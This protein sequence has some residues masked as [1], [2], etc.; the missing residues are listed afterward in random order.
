MAETDSSRV[1]A[2]AGVSSGATGQ[3][4]RTH[5]VLLTRR[6]TLLAALGRAEAFLADYDAV[7][8][9]TKVQVRLDH[10]ENVWKS[11]EEVQTELECAEESEEGMELHEEARASFEERL[12]I[13]KAELT[14]KLPVIPIDSQI[15]QTVH[16]TSA[17]SGLKLPTISLPE[18]DGDYMQ[19]LGFHDTFLALI[20]SNTDVPAIQ[21]FHYLKA[22]L[23]G[24]AAQLI[25]SIAISAANYNLAWDALVGRYANDYLL[26]KRHLQALFD[27]HPMK[28]ETAVTL[29][30]LVDEF[31]RHVKTL[32]QMGE[33]TAQWSS[34][35][36][37]LLC[38]RLHDD[39][40]KAWE[41]HASTVDDPNYSCLIDFLQRRMRVLESISVN[42]HASPCYGNSA[43]SNLKRSTQFR[44]SSNAATTNSGS[45]C[46]ACG[47]EH[48]ITRCQKFNGFSVAQRRQLVFKK[49]L[50]NN[51]LKGDHMAKDC[52]SNFNCRH[53]NMRHHSFLHSASYEGSQRSAPETHFSSTPVVV[54]NAPPLVG[55]PSVQSTVA[56]TENILD[57]EVSAPVQQPRENVFLQTVLVKIVD[58]FGQDH[59]ARAL[60][61]SASQPNLITERLAR[62]LRLRRSNVNVTIHGAGQLQQTVRNSIVAQVK[63]RGG[64]FDLGI[65]FLVIDKVTA[66]L[67][68]QDITIADWQIPDELPLADPAFNMRQRID[69]VLGAKHYHSFFPSA[70]RIQLGEQLPHLMK[71]VFGWVV[72]GSASLQQLTQPS[73]STVSSYNTVTV[74]MISLEDSIERFWKI[75]DLQ[76]SDNYSVEERHCESLFQST[77]AR[78]AEGRYMVRLPRKPDFDAMMGESR[79]S[80]LRRCEMLERRLERNSTLKEEYHKFLQDYLSLGHMRL[81]E[82]GSKVTGA[83]YYLPHHPVLKESSTTTK[84]RV[85]FDGS[86]KTST[87]YSLNEALCVGPVVQDDLLSI[88]LRFRTYQVAL[89]GDIAKMYR[90]V[91]VHPDDTPLQRI[92]WRFSTDTPVQTYELL[93]V[94]YGLTPSS[95][96]ATRALQQL[97]ADEGDAYSLAGPALRKNFY[98]DDFIGGASSTAEVIRLREE[99]SDLMQ[100]G[101]LELR[102]WTSNRFEVLQGLDEDHIGT[103]ST[104]SFT[105]NETTKALGIGWEPENDFLRF[106]SMVQPREAPP[107]K[108]TILSDIAKLFDP[109]GLIA[110]VVVR[111]KIL[112]QELW[113]LSCDWDEPVP[114]TVR[115]KWE[116]FSSEL[117]LI[118]SYRVERCAFLPD[119]RVE[120]HTFADASQDAYGACTYARCKNDQGEVKIILLASKSRVAPLKR[121]SIARLELCAAVLAAHL[122]HRIKQAIDVSISAA[123]FWSDSS[124]TL[125]W[126]QSPPN[127]WKT[128]V[129][130]RVSEVQHY[131]HGC[132]W[133]HI[134]GVENPADLVSRGLSVEDFLCSDLWKRGPAWLSSSSEHWPISKPSEV[135]D[136]VLEIKQLVAIVQTPSTCN[137]LFLRWSSYRRLLNC[138]AI[139]LRF[140]KNARIKAR[141]QSIPTTEPVSQILTVEY[142]TQAKTLLLRLAQRDAFREE[143]KDLKAGKPLPKRSHIRQMNPFIDPEGVMRVGGRLNLSQ[144]PYQSKHPALLPSN[145]PFP[146]LIAEHYHLKLLHGDGRLLLSVI[147]EEFWPLHGRQLVRSTTR[148]C[149]RCV[150]QNPQ[151]CQQQ[152]GQL[153]TSRVTPSR[154]FSVTGVDYAGPLYMK[155]VHKKAAPAK[156]YLCL[157]VCF[158][159]KAVHLELVGD[160]STKGFL[161]ALRR[162]ISHHG[163]PTHLHSDNGKNFEGAKRELAELFLML[164]N[165]H[166]REKLAVICAEEGI[167]WHFTPPKAPHFG[168]LWEA[169]VKVAKKH[170]L[171]QLGPTRLSYEEMCTVLCQIEAAMNSR[172]LLPL[173]DDPNDLA[174]LT[175]A[176]FLIG[177]SMCAL[178]DPELLHIPA[179]RLD[180]YETLQLHVQQ[181]W[182]HWRKEYL[183]EL[184]KDTK[185]AARNNNIQPGRMVV[186]VDEHLPPVRWPLARIVSLRPGMDDITRVVTLRTQRGI[187]TRP[188]TKICL[189]PVASASSEERFAIEA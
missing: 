28:K 176:H 86:A 134:S 158:V 25:E 132:R 70:A 8:D 127:V 114:D 63:S 89:V 167:T 103:Q 65:S 67:P 18:F 131:T 102:K 155:P 58:A 17:L 143:M 175:P 69:M 88:V 97:A 4:S 9:A 169:A 168:G 125:Q 49:R 186:I 152:I 180:H 44:L 119:S 179:N 166:E 101:G 23:K 139:C 121:L 183:Q 39:T 162:F 141:T 189:L 71:S 130:N 172:P 138:T 1:N 72:T 126:L 59:L 165:Q 148:N 2:P 100:K 184:Q 14:S 29:H 56:A 99:L 41:D 43:N 171:R 3:N 27:V 187:V 185:L 38:T 83:A 107:T 5:R 47:Q 104:L 120:L 75:E 54:Q 106:D 79:A 123:Y 150:R 91:L 36:E 33:P 74:S 81:V 160:L 35:L 82:P 111:A 11:L 68:A 90:Q 52:T 133:N 92:L 32:Q 21:K 124:V 110:P 34:I 159:T 10:I 61:D 154:P 136:E 140:I 19:W 53:C 77:V 112:M 6:T 20:H 177:T 84:L 73:T 64:N 57:C 122:Y 55:K 178:P 181:F 37:H 7:R 93:T 164:R 170:L 137:F 118:S 146:K 144:L 62:L 108:R 105:P 147:R 13:I 157:F 22:A 96:L 115:R 51:C 161:A 12:L 109:L 156:A 98:I 135:A 30:A 149:F 16:P 128:F 76:M 46:P 174:A 95:F 45:K 87:G 151:P 188:I 40:L 31:E 142:L 85:V 116:S 145:H 66:D 60:L 153:P 48:F 80:A 129:A 26:K 173:S 15:L 24:E 50:C 78:T 117:P 163:T 113:L 182:V 94:T 42:N